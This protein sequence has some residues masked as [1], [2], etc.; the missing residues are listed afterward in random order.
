MR[1]SNKTNLLV[2]PVGREVLLSE[3]VHGT[4]TRIS[5][6]GEDHSVTYECE[7]WSG[8]D[9]KSGWFHPFQIKLL[10]SRIGAKIG[11]INA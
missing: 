2:H 7:W 1:D 11:F 6:T 9:R 8:S 10:D 4:V 3:G 5:I